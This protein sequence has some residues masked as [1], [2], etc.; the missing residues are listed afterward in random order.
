MFKIFKNCGNYKIQDVLNKQFFTHFHGLNINIY[1]DF[2]E[3]RHMKPRRLKLTMKNK[4]I[5]KLSQTTAKKY[6]RYITIHTLINVH[7]FIHIYVDVVLHTVLNS[8]SISKDDIVYRI[9]TFFGKDVDDINFIA[10]SLS[11]Q[12]TS[13][14]FGLIRPVESTFWYIKNVNLFTLYDQS[15]DDFYDII[16]RFAKLFIDVFVKNEYKYS[17]LLSEIK[18]RLRYYQITYDDE[19]STF[20]YLMYKYVVF[21]MFHS[22]SH[23]SIN[24][25]VPYALNNTGFFSSAAFTPPI[26]NCLNFNYLSLY[27]PERT[28]E[29]NQ[30]YETLIN[31]INHLQLKSPLEVKYFYDLE[32]LGWGT[33]S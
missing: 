21:N 29:M 13:G 9:V 5:T 12:D 10:T 23:V 18:E 31:D 2:H 33:S 3:Y 16:S 4:L 17:T 8:S 15:N 20:K 6:I 7:T 26:N 11:F 22:M 14:I 1:P 24:S 28:S 25:L 30:L 27:F 32:N 19:A